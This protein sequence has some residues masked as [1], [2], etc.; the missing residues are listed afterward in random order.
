MKIYDLIDKKIVILGFGKEG[1][2]LFEF[3][4]NIGASQI[5][6]VDEKAVEANKTDGDCVINEPFE[7][8]D[9]NCYDVVLR[10]P[11][12][13]YAR[14]EALLG[15]KN[16]ISSAVD[17]ML[18]TANCV[19]IG[20]TG[21]KGKSTTVK[22]I[23]R[24]L[25]LSEKK[26][27]LGGNIGL[28]PLEQ[29]ESLSEEDFLLLELSS[30]QL[31]GL[32]VSPD[33]AVVL[34]IGSDHLDYH[35]NLGEYIEAKSAICAF[36]QAGDKLIYYQDAIGAKLSEKSKAKK[37]TYSEQQLQANCFKKNDGVCCSVEN[38][39]EKQYLGLEK[40][41]TEYKIPF[42][43]L[44]CAF[45]FAYA[46]NLDFDIAQLFEGFEKLP[47]RIELARQVGGVEFFNDSA[48]TNPISTIEAIK[49]IS[50]PFVL[51]AGGSSKSL[52]YNQMGEDLA[53]NVNVKAVF[54]YG[55]TAQEIKSALDQAHFNSDVQMVGD[56]Q[57]AV[58]KSF[59]FAKEKLIEVVLFSPGSASFDN[60]QNYQERGRMFNEIVKGL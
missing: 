35:A 38:M 6:V 52:S 51:I 59:V 14:V 21:T 49:T 20:V 46:M 22:I 5:D 33:I 28:V 32:K 25:E 50:K 56:L 16:K 45:G 17:L 48:S 36:Q 19:T 37:I 30:F 34:P 57:E 13:S 26:V 8:V 43:N 2:A 31:D 58:N 7:N 10:S 40:Y 55:N 4:K 23:Q 18:S 12:V 53:R 60:F 44:I 29:I 42:I 39:P 3:L 9:L 47:F 11:G 15:D 54:L 24:M 41:S 1:R 27:V